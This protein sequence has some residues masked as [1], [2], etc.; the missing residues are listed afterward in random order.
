LWILTGLAIATRLGWVLAVHPP[1]AHAFSDMAHYV[2]RAQALAAGHVVPGMREMAWQTFGTHWILALPFALFGDGSAGEVAAGVLWGLLAAAAVP[3]TYLLAGRVGS[4]AAARVAGVAMLVWV[5]AVSSAGFFL[6]ETPFTCLQLGA[7]LGAVAALRGGRGALAAGVCAALAFAVRPQVAIFVALAGVW[8]LARRRAV[9][10]LGPR[11]LA[12]LGGPIAAMIV[13]ALVRFWIHTGY[14]GGIAE[15]AQMNLTA[16][17][18]HNVVTQ[19]FPDD[20]SRARSEAAGDTMDGRRVSLPGFRALAQLPDEHL[21]ALRPALGGESIRLVGNIGDPTVHREIR[22]RCWAATGVVEQ[23]RYSAVNVALLW[24]FAH[25]WPEISDERAPPLLLEV[26]LIFAVVFP[27]VVLAPSLVG[28]G[29]GLGVGLRRA[30]PDP[31]PLLVALQPCV[32]IGMA[33]VFFGDIRLRLP[34]DPFSLILAVLALERGWAALRRRRR[35]RGSL[36][37]PPR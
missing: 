4:L 15:N 20:A 8:W 31:G 29:L 36:P 9:P 14:W 35:S 1:A 34:Y 2:A 37:S 19:A 21:F 13:F 25:P 27:A 18:C 10:R 5:P 26:G 22:A 12:A 33:A 17:R 3:L 6:A 7:T 30:A 32:S 16:A 11:R 28:V 24:F 23:L